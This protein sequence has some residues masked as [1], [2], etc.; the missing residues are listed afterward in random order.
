MNFFIIIEIKR[1]IKPYMLSSIRNKEP[2]QSMPL[3]NQWI[4]M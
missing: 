3:K 1:V 2:G 4:N